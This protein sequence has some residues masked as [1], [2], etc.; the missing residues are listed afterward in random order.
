M[1]AA[2]NKHQA[3]AAC[4]KRNNKCFGGCVRCTRPTSMPTSQPG[5]LLKLLFLTPRT[6]RRMLLLW[7]IERFFVNQVRK[8]ATGLGRPNSQL[9]VHAKFKLRVY[10]AVA[11]GLAPSGGFWLHAQNGLATIVVRAPTILLSSLFCRLPGEW[12]A[13][14]LMVAYGFPGFPGTGGGLPSFTV[15]AGLCLRFIHSAC[16]RTAAPRPPCLP[17]LVL[18]AHVAC[19]T[20]RPPREAARARAP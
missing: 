11:H 15:C 8:K 6:P 16:Y 1:N 20:N 7:E 9:A 4:G 12:P 3:A 13:R 19:G 2:P 14:F 18:H 17:A 10:I 5:V